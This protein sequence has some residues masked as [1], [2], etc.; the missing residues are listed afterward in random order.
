LPFLKDPILTLGG[1]WDTIVKISSA[2]SL[3]FW[4]YVWRDKWPSTYDNFIGRHFT[5][6]N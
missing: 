2:A 3:W 1:G 5:A 4:V 6:A